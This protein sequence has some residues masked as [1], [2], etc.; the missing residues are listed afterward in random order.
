MRRHGDHR[1]RA[2]RIAREAKR[3]Q[4]PIGRPAHALGWMPVEQTYW[5]DGTPRREPLALPR[6]PGGEL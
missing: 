4:P 1:Q 6:S 3:W 5:P 2:E